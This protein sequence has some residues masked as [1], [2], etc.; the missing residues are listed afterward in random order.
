MQLYAAITALVFICSLSLI[1]V[2]TAIHDQ[3][4]RDE[5]RKLEAHLCNIDEKIK[6]YHAKIRATEEAAKDQEDYIDTLWNN[7]QSY[8]AKGW[9]IQAQNVEALVTEEEYHLDQL[10]FQIFRFVNRLAYYHNERYQTLSA[11]AK[12]GVIQFSEAI[13]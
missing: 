10:N 2:I 3:W 5:I 6:S 1:V 11:L 8:R 9:V 13:A 7:A 4:L 12:H